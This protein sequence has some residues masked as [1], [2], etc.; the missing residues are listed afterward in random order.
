MFDTHTLKARPESA[1]V[2]RWIDG[3]PMEMPLGK[4]VCVGRNYAEHAR[5][6]GNDVPEEPLLFMK[7]A[8]ALCSLHEPLVLPQGQGPVHHEV[9]MVVMIGERLS[10]ETDLE[11]IRFA[12]AAYGVGLD[13]TLRDLQSR[14]KEKGHPWERAKGFDGGAPVSGFIDARGI[15]V[16]QNLEVSL[17][18]N[19]ESRQHGHTGQML[20]PTF[21]LIAQINQVFTLEPGDLIFTG[22]VATVLTN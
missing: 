9:E 15:S 20:F 7:P 21:E 12:I 2:H 19:G 3:S 11:T 4:C 22:P 18:V 5:E 10:G 13:L 8:T 1:Y 6:L 14:L 16:R 17:E